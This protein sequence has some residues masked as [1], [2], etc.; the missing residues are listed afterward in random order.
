MVCIIF[1]FGAVFEYLEFSGL[2][3]FDCGLI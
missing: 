2:Y 1:D 3:Y